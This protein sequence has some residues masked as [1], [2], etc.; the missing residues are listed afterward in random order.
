MTLLDST[1]FVL[2]AE[3]IRLSWEIKVASCLV[4]SQSFVGETGVTWLGKRLGR[5]YMESVHFPDDTHIQ[6]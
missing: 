6:S 5:R 3:D 4:K 1:N 2:I